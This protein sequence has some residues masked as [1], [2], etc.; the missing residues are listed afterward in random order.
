MKKKLARIFA[1]SLVAVFLVMM[2]PFGASAVNLLVTTTP[3]EETAD[4]EYSG[5]TDIPLLVIKINYAPE[6]GTQTFIKTTD[7][8]YW[9]EMLFGDGEKS[10]KSYWETISDGNF[11]FTPATENYVNEEHNNVANDGIVEVTVN[12]AHPGGTNRGEVGAAITAASEY[13]DFTVFDKNGDGTVEAQELAVA[14]VC[15]GYEATRNSTQEPSNHAFWIGSTLTADGVVMSGGYIK[16]G[17]MMNDT[18]PLT[19]GTFCHELGHFLGTIDLYTNKSWGGANSPAGKVSVMAGNGSAG[20]NSDEHTGESPSYLDAFH[21]VGLGMYPYTTIGDGEYTLY[22]RQS[23]EGKY[24]ILKI[25]T[26]NPNEYYLLEN[27]Y[28]D[29]STEHFD[30]ETNYDGTRGIIIWHVDETYAKVYDRNNGGNNGADIGVAA[31]APLGEGQEVSYPYNSGVFGVAG[32]VFDCTNYE[33]PGSDTWNTSVGERWNEFFQLKIEILDDA[34]HEMRIRV[35][36]TKTGDY[37][38]DTISTVPL[39]D[40][41]TMRGQILDL[42]GQ[43]LTGVSMQ[44]ASDWQYTNILQTIDVEVNED[45][46]YGGT[47]GGLEPSEGYY[48]RIIYHMEGGDFYYED[49]ATTKK[50]AD[51]TKCVI[52][53]FRGLTDND[54]AYEYT[55]DAGEP[56]VIKFPMRKTGYVFA[57]WYTDPG[58]TEYYEVSEPAEA[59][60][61]ILYARWVEEG[62]AAQLNVVGAT[63]VNSSVN[64]AGYGVV[65]ETFHVPVVEEQE[66]MHVVWYADEACTVPFDFTQIIESTDAVTIYA[67]YEEGEAPEETEETT[68]D[69]NDTPAETTS[70]DTAD[71][72]DTTGTSGDGLST[73][74][75]IGIVAIVIVVIAVV[76]V[77]VVKKKKE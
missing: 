45:G 47:I 62:S 51:P 17:E 7:D 27:R 77:L 31:L 32:Q 30:S 43:T 58:Y 48:T 73:G 40:S 11:R 26:P 61:L 63:L 76:I 23:T 67:Q 46:W 28:F 64:P 68:A 54:R 36:G 37:P 21:I 66:G 53:F 15:A 6:S 1:A 9:Y 18:T 65:G 69:T 24:N 56:I 74:V 39:S 33:F 38:D 22:S 59:G 25:E 72:S 55:V 41:I 20:K 16:V 4:W 19:V 60:E 29:E 57:G 42:H 34:G 13:V 50:E 8:T 71:T 44:L 5:W 75:I 35:T 49:Y 10:M 12:V 52:S 14:F 2:L 3:S 70:S